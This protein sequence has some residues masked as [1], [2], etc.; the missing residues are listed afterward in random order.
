MTPECK[1]LEV[2][3]SLHAAGADALSAAEAARVAAHL[4]GCPA[5]REAERQEAEL[6]GLV[7]LPEPAP[8]EAAALAELPARALRELRRRERR[9]TWLR[10]VGAGAGIAAAAAA[11]IAMLLLPALRQ[12]PGLPEVP[13]AGAAAAEPTQ[14]AAGAA[15]DEDD[16]DAADDGTSTSSTMSDAVL[17]AYDAGVGG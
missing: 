15:F 16:L 9:F 7:R 12:H 4:E 14:V 11:V 13:G 6:L 1:E 3:R 17:A 10:R 2:L 5:C 8:A